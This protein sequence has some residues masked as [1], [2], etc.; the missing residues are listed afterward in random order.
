M[1]A[2]TAEAAAE[3]EQRQHF[4]VGG[5]QPTIFELIKEK[6][7]KLIVRPLILT[8]KNAR[9]AQAMKCGHLCGNG[10]RCRRF[11]AEPPHRNVFH[12]ADDC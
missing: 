10:L 2:S 9:E 11:S 1:P 12:C 8:V 7:M 4:C 5:L 3:A 6:G